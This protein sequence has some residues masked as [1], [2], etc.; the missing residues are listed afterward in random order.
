M[1]TASRAMFQ[2]TQNCVLAIFFRNTDRT[3]N[4]SNKL[5]RGGTGERGAPIL[6]PQKLLLPVHES[7]KELHELSSTSGKQGEGNART[8][9]GTWGEQRSVGDGQNK[10][11]R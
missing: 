1:A 9:E 4:S 8:D 5:D 6:N 7:R 11:Y 3:R 2:S 10:G